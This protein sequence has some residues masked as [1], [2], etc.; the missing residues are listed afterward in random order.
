MVEETEVRERIGTMKENYEEKLNRKLDMLFEK[1][2]DIEDKL[3]YERMEREEKEIKKQQHE[4][5]CHRED[6]NY[7]KNDMYERNRRQREAFRKG[8]WD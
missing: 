8:Y 3:I 2:L 6:L 5:D 1:V 4:L 7:R